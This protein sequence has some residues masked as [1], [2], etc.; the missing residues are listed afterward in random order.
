M[1]TLPSQ[2]ATA[3]YWIPDVGIGPPDAMK[4]V[5]I[6]LRDLT[7]WRPNI[8]FLFCATFTSPDA[9]SIDPDIV[10]QMADVKK[11]QDYG[12]KVLLSI[13]GAKG[14][15][16]DND[17]NHWA[18]AKM[19][20]AWIDGYGLD[21]IDIDNEDGPTANV[22]NFMNTAGSL[23][24]ALSG[25][26]LTKALWSDIPPS[27]D[28]FNTPV[29]PGLPNAGKRLAQLL[30]LGCNM[31]YGHNYDKQ[32]HDLR[33]YNKAGL[34]WN[35]LMIGVQAGPP[36]DDWMTKIDVTYQLSK[37]SVAP[38]SPAKDIPPIR[39]MMLFTHTQDI[40]QFTFRKQNDP[41]HMYPNPND[42]QWFRTIVAGINGQPQPPD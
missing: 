24:E 29:G 6:P 11:L 7:S 17:R 34:Q 2:G 15:G 40:Q 23:R 39:G 27:T 32:I 1:S 5:Q 4:H 25:K 16:W 42:H 35:Q 9:I 38:Q 19:V 28:Y 13:K 12:M 26:L 30:D 36:D 10:P 14:I 37:W 33:D 18:F 31:A 22:Q 20:R 3:V 41:A 21:G 8:V